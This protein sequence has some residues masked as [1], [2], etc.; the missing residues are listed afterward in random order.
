M[1]ESTAMWL[2]LA[3]GAFWHL[4]IILYIYHLSPTLSVHLN[5]EHRHP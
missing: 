4:L 1:S 3:T 5:K 2:L